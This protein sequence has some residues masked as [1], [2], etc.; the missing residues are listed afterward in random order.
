M[1]PDTELELW[2]EQ[3]LADSQPVVPAALRRKVER[4]SRAMRWMLLA[5]V[6]VTVVIGGGCTLLTLREPTGEMI[7][8]AAGAWVLFATAWTFALL[9][10]RGTW[11]PEQAT[12]SAFIDLSLR[13]CRRRLTAAYFGGCFYAVEMAF[14]LTWIYQYNSHRGPVTLLDVLSSASAIMF[15]LITVALAGWL[16]WYRKRRLA[17]LEYLQELQEQL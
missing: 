7:V 8:L 13:R 10:R 15:G 6:F 12:T 3:W 5:E 11:R 17:E 4:Q 9:N 16:I 2:R 1:T 14:C